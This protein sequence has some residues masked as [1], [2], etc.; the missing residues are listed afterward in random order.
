[1]NHSVFNTTHQQ[2]D[3][4]SKIVVGLERISEVFKVLLWEHGKSVGLSPIQ[5]Q[6]LIFIAYHKYE[7][8]NVSHLALEFNV[9]KPTI[10]D[11]VKILDSKKL[12]VKDFSAHDKR[13]YSIQLSDDGRKIVS[14]TENFANPIKSQLSNIEELD[15]FYNLLS[16]LIYKLHT[17]GLLSVQRLCYSCKFYDKN[18]GGHY[19]NLLEKPLYTNDIRLD[20]PEF[21]KASS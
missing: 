9:S 1:M 15:S 6:I 16:T 8:C 19:C 7:F 4:A 3:V 12:I 21:T 5:I 14:Q 17:T 13:R 10:S 20:C 18:E 11:A 2:M